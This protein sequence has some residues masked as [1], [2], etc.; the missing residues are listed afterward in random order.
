MTSI[1]TV[2]RVREDQGTVVLFHGTTEDGV[3]V[4]LGVDHR[5]AAGLA[6]RLADGPVDCEVEWWQVVDM[7]FF[8]L[9][10]FLREV[11]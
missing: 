4:T 6:E 7:P 9:P 8:S 1:V 3:E 2:D 10:R 5:M 11:Q